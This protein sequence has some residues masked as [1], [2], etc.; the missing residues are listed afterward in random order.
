M[1]LIKCDECGQMMSDK[2]E[3]CPRC[4]NPNHLRE[5]APNAASGQPVYTY[6]NDE[7]EGNKK[8]PWL[9]A[10]VAA[11]AV[12]VIG[13][14]LWYMFNGG[15]E[16][17]VKQFIEQFA[18]AVSANDKA[19]ISQMYPNAALA[20]AIQLDYNGGTVQVVMPDGNDTIDVKLSSE[21]SVRLVKDADK[22]YRIVSSRGLFSYPPEKLSFAKATGWYDA[23]L[24]DHENA[25]R[26]SDQG[27]PQYLLKTFNESIKKGLSIVSVGTYGDQYIDNDPDSWIYADG[28]T[29]TVKNNTS[30]DIPGSAYDILF[31]KGYWGGGTMESEVVAGK[32][33]PSGGAVTLRTT[34][35]GT[36]MESDANQTLR[37]KG[38]SMDEFLAIFKATGHEYDEY[39]KTEHKSFV[40]AE[41]LEFIVEGLMG[42]CGTRVI[43]NGNEGTLFYNPNGADIQ[44]V[45]QRGL[46]LVNY[47]PK[48]GQ[49]VLQVHKIDGTKTGQL[50]G[51]LKNGTYSGTFQSASGSTSSF[52]FK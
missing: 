21:Q 39:V 41:S 51:T 9:L 49:L 42:S 17:A 10:A 8:K 2:A 48:T 3:S 26:L 33:I 46:S 28:C 30:F 16:K 18:K 40:G 50:V 6:E 43:M 29:F 15:E 52:S 4:G 36:D 31:K 35:L 19:R 32:D 20:E 11:L 5:Q 1:A 38:F 22:G 24:D 14:G 34:K 7:G 37:V 25:L 23:R 13:G 12:M 44:C 47:D 45:E 27:F